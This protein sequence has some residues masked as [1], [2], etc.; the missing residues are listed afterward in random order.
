MDPS[1]QPPHTT[2]WNLDLTVLPWGFPL[3]PSPQRSLFPVPSCLTV[4]NFLFP[5][6]LSCPTFWVHWVS[7]SLHVSLSRINLPLAKIIEHV[8]AL[9]AHF[10]RT[11]KEIWRKWHVCFMDEEFLNASTTWSGHKAKQAERT[12]WMLIIFTRHNVVWWNE[13]F[14]FWGFPGV[15][16]QLSCSGDIIWTLILGCHVQLAEAQYSLQTK[17]KPSS[18]QMSWA[19]F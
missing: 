1:W 12:N 8:Y 14:F 7:F 19:G 13:L 4:P 16:T 18:K 11:A 9:K 15:Q 3:P 5:A 6:Q 2:D 10:L 17:T